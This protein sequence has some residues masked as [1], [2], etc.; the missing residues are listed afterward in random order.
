MPTL[1]NSSKVDPSNWKTKNKKQ[2]PNKKI[3]KI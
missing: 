3:K 1:L 2:Q